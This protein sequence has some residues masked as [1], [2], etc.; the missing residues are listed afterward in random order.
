MLEGKTEKPCERFIYF[1]RALASP[2]RNEYHSVGE[3]IPMV[4]KFQC[5]ECRKGENSELIDVLPNRRYR[6]R[7]GVCG[8]TYILTASEDDER[9]CEKP[10][11][12]C[13]CSG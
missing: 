7:C 11:E 6:M 9:R 1:L 4:L 12:G 8:C 5:P 3:V 13:S 10:S 2:K